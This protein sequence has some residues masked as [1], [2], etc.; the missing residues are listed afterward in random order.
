MSQLKLDILNS[1]LSF[2]TITEESGESFASIF[3]PKIIHHP[4]GELDFGHRKVETE[5]GCEIYEIILWLWELL[6]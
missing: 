3:K 1:A 5:D 4:I 2:T 6:H